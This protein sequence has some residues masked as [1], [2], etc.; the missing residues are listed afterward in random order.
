M[1]WN[2]E[3]ETVFHPKAV[4]IVGVSADAKRGQVWSGGGGGF[5]TV[6]EQLE[7]KGHIYPV[8]PKATEIMGYKVYPTVSSI[9]EHIDLVIMAVPAKFAPAV[10]E[11]CIKA[12]AKNIHMFTA[13]FEETGE[14]EGIELGKQVR[15]IARRGG[16]RIIGPNCMGLYV[17]EAGIGTFDQLPKQSGDVVFLSQSGGHLNWYAHYGPNYGIYFDKGISFGNAYIF[18]STDYLEYLERDPKVKFI[19]MYLE[20]VKDGAKLRRQVTRINRTRPV[21]IWKA[22]LTATGARAVASHTASLAGQES[23]WKG[24]F[25]QTGAVQ[26]NSLEE[27]AEA[28]MTFRCLKPPKG[29]RVAVMSLGGGTSVSAADICSREGLEVPPLSQATQNELKK[30]ISLAGASIRNPL[31][32]GLIFRDVSVLERELKLVAAD[33]SIDMMI[34]MPHLDMARHVVNELLDYLCNF[35]KNHPSGKSAVIVFHSFGNDP[36]EAALRAKL[37]V[38]L[39][40]KGIAVYSSLTAAS[41]ALARFANYH[42]IQ[43]EMAD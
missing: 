22:G 21:V 24:F 39:P 18:D 9:P 40:N 1:A 42:R 33:P 5:L 43:R 25:A 30:F 27:M 38:E 13:G 36:W 37:Q 8:N 14:V 2:A 16:L 11:D 29:N 15:E 6:L 12:D 26:V 10:L 23:V 31:D 4:A 7:F 17:P 32:T 28:T 3:L 41:R 35:A 34:L 19:S 20:G